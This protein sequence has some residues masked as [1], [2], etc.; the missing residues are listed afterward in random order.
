MCLISLRWDAAKKSLALR[1]NRDEFKARPTAPA[2]WWDGWW[3]GKDLEAG[4]TWLAIGP[5]R[6]ACVTNVREPGTPPGSRSR[7]EL[8]VRFVTGS[9]SAADFCL[10]LQGEDYSGFNLLAFDGHALWYASNRA[11]AQ[12]L[13][14][15]VHGMSNA[16]LNTPWPK[17]R[18]V[19][20]A[21]HDSDAAAKQAMLNPEPYPDHQLPKTGV[22]VAW[23]RMLSAAFIQGEDYGTRCHTEVNYRGGQFEAQEQTFEPPGL[24]SVVVEPSQHA[25]GK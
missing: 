19:T 21:F 16:A 12:A 6:M 9:A 17:L 15:G 20:Q 22:P 10:A 2:Q 5:G 11:P 3:G 1:A 4:G 14:S 24:A 8:P 7:G 25:G 18:A 23:E 13:A